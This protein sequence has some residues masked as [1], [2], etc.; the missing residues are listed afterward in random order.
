MGDL[1]GKNKLW[2]SPCNDARGKIIETFLENKDMVC[3]NKGEPTHINYNGTLSHLDLVISSNNLALNLDCCVLDE[4][5]GSDHYPLEITL[6]V[7]IPIINNT[8]PNNYNL[9]KADWAL[10]RTTI[11]DSSIL[12]EEI[13]DLEIQYDKFVSLIM[14]ARDLAI[15]K[16]TNNFKHK[17]TP[18]WNKECSEAKKNKKRATKNL[19]KLNS[20]IN[21]NY[22]KE[23]KK[24]FRNIVMESKQLYWEKLCE[25]INYKTKISEIWKKVKY[26][27]GLSSK[28]K[29]I[30]TKPNG[31]L[32]EDN[33]IA[34]NFALTFSQISRE[35][36]QG[37]D[38]TNLRNLTVNS[39]LDNYKT[40]SIYLSLN[41]LILEDSNMLNE[42]LH[43]SELDI[44]FNSVNK[45]SAPGFD[46]LTYLYL[47][48]LPDNAKH[49]YLNLLNF[50]W[51]YN[52][53]PDLWKLAIVKPILK[54]NKDKKIRVL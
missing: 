9:D 26:L 34:N 47:I 24:K 11:Q 45:K 35:I 42:P 10:F 31:D 41:D 14:I 27:K 33:N 2:G 46:N 6:N 4:T 25:G 38:T 39:F 36:Q 43:M 30:I 22:Y 23:C 18:F 8:L 54:P 49:Y 51:K 5:W 32:E 17:Y 28:S 1:N 12:K 21:Q 13:E 44:V 19:R 15:P 29:V 37:K 48:N 53:I 3:H 16:R 52:I 20:V 40:S 50:S 7:G